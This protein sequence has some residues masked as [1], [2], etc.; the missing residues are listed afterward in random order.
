MAG[1]R[2]AERYAELIRQQV[3]V[4]LQ[5]EFEDFADLFITITDV[6]MSSDLRNVKIYYSILGGQDVKKTA[7]GLF[8]KNKSQIKFKLGK[9]IQFRSVPDFNFI[10]DETSAR[11]ARLDELFNKIKE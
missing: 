4:I 11:V 9:R 3:T 10:Y 7:E 8:K 5:H 1:S 6:N 2:R